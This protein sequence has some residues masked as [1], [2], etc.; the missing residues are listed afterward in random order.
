MQA[1]PTVSLLVPCYNA[2][3]YI[4]DFI[5]S[6]SRQTIPFDEVLFY[7]DASTDSTAEILR[8]RNFGR[9][10]SGKFNK[11]PSIGRNIL[12]RESTGQL[13]HF[14]DIDDWLEPTFLEQTLQALSE[15]WDIV[16]TNIRV[17]DRETG[18][19]IQIH[20]YSEL[21][22]SNDP[23]EF[24]LTHCC[25]PINGLYRRE[26]LEK[27][28]GFRETISRDEDPDL[29]IRLAYSGVRIRSLPLPLAI[30][31]FGSGSY[32]STSYIACWHE[33]LKALQYY[34]Q[35]LPQK[36]H[37]ILCTNSVR[38]IYLCAACGDLQLAHNYLDFCES[39]GGQEEL[40]L[41]ASVP[42]KL[43][44][45]ILGHRNALNL[46][47]GSIGRRIRKIWPWRIG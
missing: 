8:Q 34:A 3:D 12:L 6:M 4:L 11:G 5:E 39:L 33:H 32:S 23:T 47:F 35:E 14:H 19:N 28:G 36:Y 15:E 24:F 17:I 9:V 38:M 44:I 41:A 10:I 7:D 20:D 45:R 29:H 40:G 27:I 43:L 18:K 1:N 13:I 37:S 30:N 21:M 26:V 22:S 25:Y 16:L 42:M 46:R 2:E 31:R